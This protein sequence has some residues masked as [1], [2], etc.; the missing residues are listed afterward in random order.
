[1]LGGSFACEPVCELLRAVVER[2]SIGQEASK[3]N[4]EAAL[5]LRQMT[6]GKFSVITGPT[7]EVLDIDRI[8]SSFLFQTAAAMRATCLAS[9]HEYRFS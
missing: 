1:M 7:A 6:E 9:W 3:K 8:F 2:V 4:V 5:F